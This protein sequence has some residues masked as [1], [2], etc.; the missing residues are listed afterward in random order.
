MKAGFVSQ[1]G[2]IGRVVLAIALLSIAACTPQ[3]W[4]VG[5]ADP[6]ASRSDENDGGMGGSSEGSY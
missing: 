2:I 4:D 5:S 3:S 1:L 6:V